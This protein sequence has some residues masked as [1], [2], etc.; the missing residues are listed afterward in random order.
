M[1][2]LKHIVFSGGSTNVLGFLGFLKYLTE[3]N[4]LNNIESYTATS[5]GSMLAYFLSIGYTWY[6]L[7]QF[8]KSFDHRK[9]IDFN[10]DNFIESYGFSSNDKFTHFLIKLTEHKNIDPNITFKQ[11]FEKTK[12]KLTVT[13]SCINDGGS[14]YFNYLKYPDMEVIQ[15]IKISCCIPFIFSPIVFDNKVW[16]DGGLFLNYPIEYHDDEIDETI[17]MTIKDSCIEKCHVDLSDVTSYMS[18]VIK[19]ILNGDIKK[20]SQK[21]EEYTLNFSYNQGV[22]SNLDI[23]SEY[24]E[25]IINNCYNDM[26]DQ[27]YKISKF[28]DDIEHNNSTT[29]IYSESE[30]IENLVKE[31]ED[32]YYS[33]QLFVDSD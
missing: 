9:V 30:N 1:P 5:A 3:N 4:L 8:N 32:D 28:I 6:D 31:I 23:T 22:M 27:K 12:I 26:E 24:I 11:H 18:A 16:V 15:A 13:G 14:E 25:E 29:D 33:E 19:C 21:Y 10:I 2:K 7:Y 17:G 20:I